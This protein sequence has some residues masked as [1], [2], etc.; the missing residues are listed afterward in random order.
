MN[1]RF[2]HFHP[3]AKLATLVVLSVVAY[4]HSSLAV[5]F[6]CGV[7]LVLLLALR[8]RGLCAASPIIAVPIV[9]FALVTTLPHSASA[10]WAAFRFA[11]PLLAITFAAALFG[12][13]YGRS[14]TLLFARWV[15]SRPRV[16][17]AAIFVTRTLPTF[18]AA[19]RDV[20]NAAAARGFR[21]SICNFLSL[22]VL[23][24]L[25][26]P[27]LIRLLRET[28]AMWLDAVMRTADVSRIPRPRLRLGDFALFVV[29]VCWLIV[30]R[31]VH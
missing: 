1:L 19:C 11:V 17:C 6:Y 20:F 28:L 12:C 27:I 9:A 5:A 16:A 25:M 15:S 10:L 23:R 22:R 3:A 14:D 30:P 29:L 2:P 31:Y 4:T 8:L 24:A 21:L 7:M 18:T 13:W 26:A